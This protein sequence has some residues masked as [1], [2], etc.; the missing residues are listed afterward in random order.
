MSDLKDWSYPV[1]GKK[2][3]REYNTSNKFTR[4]L[5]DIQPKINLT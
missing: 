1:R 3:K 5:H 4:D 2:T